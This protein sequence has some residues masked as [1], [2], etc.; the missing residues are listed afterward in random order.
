VKFEDGIGRDWQ[1][2]CDSGNRSMVVEVNR[3]YFAEI[4]R[5]LSSV[6]VL[7]T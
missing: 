6:K 5:E 3:E 2:V 4:V 1:E 7:G